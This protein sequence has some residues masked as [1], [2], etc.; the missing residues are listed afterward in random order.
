MWGWVVVV[1]AWF[2]M[3][4]IAG[5]LASF[6]NIVE[7]LGQEFN[8]TK[9]ITGACVRAQRE[10]FYSSDKVQRKRSRSADAREAAAAAG[11]ACVLARLSLMMN[12]RR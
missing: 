11:G 9:L 1:A 3:V 6:G 5:L 12:R 2:V 8:S 7:P 10:M 4:P